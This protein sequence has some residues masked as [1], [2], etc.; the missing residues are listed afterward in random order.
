MGDS[1]KLPNSGPGSYRFVEHHRYLDALLEA[2]DVRARVTFV[3][4]D[5]GSAL[6]F[7]W[8]NRHREAVKGIA[9]MEAM[10][11]GS[12]WSP[13][14]AWSHTVSTATSPLRRE[15]QRRPARRDMLRAGPAKPPCPFIS[16]VNEHSLFARCLESVATQRV[17]VGHAHAAALVGAGST[18]PFP[19]ARA[20]L[21][22]CLTRNVIGRRTRARGVNEITARRLR[23][24]GR[25]TVGSTGIPSRRGIGL[26]RA[27]GWG[28]AVGWSRSAIL[29]VRL[30][31]PGGRSQN[32]HGCDSDQC[33]F[34]RYLPESVR[35]KVTPA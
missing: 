31:D 22:I 10:A 16:G 11:H 14:R 6:G 35:R 20:L 23:D 25:A 33:A 8:A 1:D 7:D 30:S 34:H 24:T 27:I 19:R 17:D 18:V 9:L 28:S 3:I 13:A 29:C 4:H 26:R 2:L 5:W 12:R 15:S 21:S 32:A